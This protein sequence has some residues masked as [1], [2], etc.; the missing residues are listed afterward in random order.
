MS[1]ELA[2][3]ETDGW[4]LESAELRHAE[5][6]DTFWIPPRQDR[7][8]IAVGQLAQ[9]LFKIAIPND[10][11]GEFNVERMWVEV[12]RRVDEVYIGML[13]NRPASVESDDTLELGAEILFRPEHVIDIR[14][15]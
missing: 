15:A 6:P 13:R 10:P 4:M 2:S 5:S 11:D 14:K 3:L 7:E 9:L 1:R 8:S 12:K